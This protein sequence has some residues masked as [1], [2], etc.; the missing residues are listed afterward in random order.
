MTAPGPYRTPGVSE[1]EE[2]AA[3]TRA[4]DEAREAAALRLL[5]IVP[6]EIVAILQERERARERAAVVRFLRLRRTRDSAALAD[7]I[8]NGDHVPKA[9]T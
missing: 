3:V 7:E 2:Q 6:R 8:E 1:A 9:G 5:E 4:L